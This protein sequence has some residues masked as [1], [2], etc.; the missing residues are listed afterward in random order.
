M[1]MIRWREDLQILI[2][3]VESNRDMNRQRNRYE[4]AKQMG[5][6]NKAGNDNGDIDNVMTMMIN[7][8]ITFR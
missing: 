3:L 2:D 7:T 5:K 6:I 1:V 4:Y 8:M